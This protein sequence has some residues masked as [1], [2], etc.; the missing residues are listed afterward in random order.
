[1]VSQGEE[2]PALQDDGVAGE[3][4]GP[5][6]GM[7]GAGIESLPACAALGNPCSGTPFLEFRS[8]GFDVVVRPS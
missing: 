3:A 6:V 8:G 1:M 7:M 2:L 5:V 4:F